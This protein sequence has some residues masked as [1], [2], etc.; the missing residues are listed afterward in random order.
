MDNFHSEERLLTVFIN[1]HAFL[2]NPTK[3]N[4]I[5]K[6]LGKDIKQTKNEY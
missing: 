4:N 3:L 6:G 1:V 5:R 2:V